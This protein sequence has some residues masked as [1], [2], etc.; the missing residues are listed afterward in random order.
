M[1]NDG[2]IP[3]SVTFRSFDNVRHVIPVLT[4]VGHAQVVSQP[5][6]RHD[7]HV[8]P[9]LL[10]PDVG[11]VHTKD[12]EQEPDLPHNS[13]KLQHVLLAP[14]LNEGQQE[15][16]TDLPPREA[17]WSPRNPIGI[18]KEGCDVW[19]HLRDDAEVR[20]PKLSDSLHR[21]VALEGSVSHSNFFQRGFFVMFEEGIWAKG[22]VCSSLHQKHWLEQDRNATRRKHSRYESHLRRRYVV[23]K[24][25]GKAIR[26]SSPGRS[27]G[28]VDHSSSFFERLLER[29]VQRK[30]LKM[31]LALL[32]TVH[33]TASEDHAYLPEFRSW[34]STLRTLLNP[35]ILKLRQL[36]QSLCVGSRS[37]ERKDHRSE[38]RP[39]EDIG[40]QILRQQRAKKPFMVEP[41]AGTAREKQRRPAVACD[42][43]VHE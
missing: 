22:A 31:L 32:Q 6:V 36:L 14:A 2:E 5:D 12:A 30:P 27:A 4:V 37:Q 38:R 1:G 39:T 23:Q 34:K 13:Q 11:P 35:Q 24:D 26:L 20:V 18:V 28:D 25:L 16:S 33:V 8:S 21:C 3:P 7:V 29:H 42:G 9:F 19:V 40:H 17:H 41:N 10:R 15:S 43:T